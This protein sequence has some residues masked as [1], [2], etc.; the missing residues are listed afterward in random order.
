M[1]T[2]ANPWCLL[3]LLIIPAIIA[4]YIYNRKRLTAE[5]R[6]SSTKVFQEMPKTYK[7]YL[8]YLPLALH[9]LALAALIIAIARPQKSDSWSNQTTEGIDIVM[10]VDISSSMLAEDLKPNRLRAAKKVA[11]EFISSRHN[12][13]IGL[14]VFA[15]ESFTQCPLTINHAELINLLNGIESGM[16]EDGTAIGSGLATAVNRIKDSKA[17]SK[18]IILLTDGSNNRGQIAPSTAGE[19]AKSFG[20]RVYTIGVGTRGMAP[21]PFQTPYGVQYQDVEVDIDE[22]SLKNIAETTGGEY[23]RATD[24]KSLSSI[25]REIDKLEKTKIEVKEFSKKEELYHWFVLVLVVCLIGEITL[26]N[27]VFKSIP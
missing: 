9:M 15:G 24:T 21:Y 4:Y 12:D 10:S 5:I 17:K 25:Y 6:F 20:I 2:F 7:H 1:I 22:E 16:I 13:N 19:I 18:V 8:R 14:V 3:L 27:T 11:T 23:F 26:R